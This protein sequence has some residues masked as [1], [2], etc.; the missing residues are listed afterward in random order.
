MKEHQGSM[1]AAAVLLSSK[2]NQVWGESMARLRTTPKPL[3]TSW[4]Q[5]HPAPSLYQ[6]RQ[7]A[8]WAQSPLQL[9]PIKS[10]L[11]ANLPDEFNFASCMQPAWPGCC[12]LHLPLSRSAGGIRGYCSFFELPAPHSRSTTDVLRA[13][14]WHHCGGPEQRIQAPPAPTHGHNQHGKLPGILP[15]LRAYFTPQ[16]HK[17]RPDPARWGTNANGMSLWQ[18]PSHFLNSRYYLQTSFLASFPDSSS[19]IQCPWLPI[20]WWQMPFR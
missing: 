8:H 1:L 18:Q 2:E 7:S 19:S 14:Q 6:G 13:S 10:L 9:Q 4:S 12:S 20:T 3:K 17:H 15:P 11:I 16:E 5:L